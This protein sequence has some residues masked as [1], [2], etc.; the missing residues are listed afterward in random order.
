M[1]SARCGIS[2]TIRKV[3]SRNAISKLEQAFEIKDGLEKEGMTIA[4]EVV[5]EL[6]KENNGDVDMTYCV[7][8]ELACPVDKDCSPGVEQLDS[9]VEDVLNHLE[10]L[11]HIHRN[12]GCDDRHQHQSNVLLETINRDMVRDV[13][14]YNS[15]D[16][17]S[18]KHQLECLLLED[19]VTDSVAPCRKSSPE[20]LIDMASDLLPKKSL[21]KL[22][23]DES[24]RD[25]A[26]SDGDSDDMILG[27]CLSRVIAIVQGDDDYGDDEDNSAFMS[28]SSD[29]SE[30]KRKL[31]HDRDYS[32][33]NHELTCE[34]IFEIGSYKHS[35]VIQLREIFLDASD[36]TLISAFV[37]NEFDLEKTIA[38]LLNSNSNASGQSETGNEENQI[39]N[40]KDVFSFADVVKTRPQ[41]N[42][43]SS[44][45][46]CVVNGNGNI[47][48]ENNRW[49]S[50]AQ[51]RSPISTREH[52]SRFRILHVY[53]A[54]DRLK[55][56][57]PGIDITFNNETRSIDFHGFKSHAT[58]SSCVQVDL[59]GLLVVEAMNLCRKVLKFYKY[60]KND[61]NSTLN[62]KG[63]VVLCTIC[64]IVGR[65]VHSAGGKSRLKPALTKLLTTDDECSALVRKIDL[66]TEGLISI[67]V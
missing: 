66:S 41:S 24:G 2:T 9:L 44:S 40:T 57:N 45:Q 67:R 39:L 64:F 51:A 31:H 46:A 35:G 55:V 22:W 12:D 6:L 19:D 14:I 21:Q 36:V 65:G 10:I 1:E 7:S 47:V 30:H 61:Q 34:D 60:Y 27:R 23:Q 3:R 8:R 5:Q 20:T 59:H 15:L 56:N 48:T 42:S 38:S 13:L 52:W 26:C 28:P 16:V 53:T 33:T 29:G 54:I 18:T 32:K 62:G 43:I 37:N 49:Q 17:A 50:L 63:N 58:T 25:L 11:A 4:I